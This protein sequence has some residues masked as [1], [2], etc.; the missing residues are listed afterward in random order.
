MFTVGFLGWT[1]D[2]F[3]FFTVSMT[4]TELAED[5]NVSYSDVS[6][7]RGDPWGINWKLTN[8]GNDSHSHASVGWGHHLRHPRRPLWT[9]MANDLQF[10][11]VHCPG[12][13]IRVLHHTPT[14][15]RR[16]FALWH[17]NG[18]YAISPYSLSSVNNS[19]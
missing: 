4:V 12:T 18:G 16:P 15:S 19:I 17:C 7:V 1:W 10:V 14:I 3:D 2:A 5:F 13:W 8:L 6:W 9:E 11:L